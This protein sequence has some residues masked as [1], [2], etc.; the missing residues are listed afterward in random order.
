MPVLIAD[1][2]GRRTRALRL[3]FDPAVT[4]PAGTAIHET[5]EGSGCRCAIER[6]TLTALRDPS[7]LLGYCLSDYS[8]CPTWQ[9]EKQHVEAGH[10]RALLDMPDLERTA[11]DELRKLGG[12]IEYEPVEYTD[13]VAE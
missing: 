4:C 11:A 5:P 3:T 12:T 6:N 9:A 10:R 13:Y 8:A 1:E 7:S 2:H